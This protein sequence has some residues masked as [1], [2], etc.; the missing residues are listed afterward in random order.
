MVSCTRGALLWPRRAQTEEV[1]AG[2]CPLSPPTPDLRCLALLLER[3]ARVRL[4]QGCEQLFKTRQRILSFE[5]QP[6]CQEGRSTLSRAIPARHLQELGCLG[7]LSAVPPTTWQKPAGP[8]RRPGWW[9]LQR[10]PGRLWP[11]R[12]RRVARSHLGGH[13]EESRLGTT[14]LGC[15]ESLSSLLSASVRTRGQRDKGTHLPQHQEELPDV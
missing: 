12:T 10:A 9:G 4:T 11:W 8:E 3:S 15:R 7:H 5:A 13:S 1:P 2:L 6:L 14:T